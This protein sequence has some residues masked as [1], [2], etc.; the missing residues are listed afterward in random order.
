MRCW[1]FRAGTE[2]ALLSPPRGDLRLN[3]QV[4]AFVAR[5]FVGPEMGVGEGLDRSQSGGGWTVGARQEHLA[6][7]R[8]RCM[9]GREI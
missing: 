9:L 8:R 6:V 7:C 4:E 1:V 5:H 2:P 3:P